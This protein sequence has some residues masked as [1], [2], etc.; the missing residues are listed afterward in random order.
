MSEP[1]YFGGLQRHAPESVPESGHHPGDDGREHYH[2]SVPGCEQEHPT[3]AH[4]SAHAGEA[5]VAEA[6]PLPAQKGTHRD[7]PSGQF[8][9]DSSRGSSPAEVQHLDLSSAPDAATVASQFRRPLIV[10]GHE[11]NSPQN[12][13]GSSPVPKP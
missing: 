4:A 6:Q 2:C 9:P 11:S 5:A 7:A 10:S 3:A 12:R 8:A 13:G 1:T